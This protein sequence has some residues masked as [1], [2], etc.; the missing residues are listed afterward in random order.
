MRFIL[1]SE[2]SFEVSHPIVLIESYCFQNDFYSNYD[3]LGNRKI[4]DVNKIGARINQDLL[5]QCKTIVENYN[6]L[7]IIKAGWV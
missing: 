7:K 4:E 1:F 2:I 6:N 5:Q 3:L